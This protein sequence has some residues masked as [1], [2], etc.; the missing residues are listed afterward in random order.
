[1]H[2]S[3]AFYKHDYD[4]RVREATTFTKG[5]YVLT[6]KPSLHATS[7]STADATKKERI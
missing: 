1:M 7:N 2:K 6:D 4:R 5:I 3:Q